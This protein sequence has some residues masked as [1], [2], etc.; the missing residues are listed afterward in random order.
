[1]QDAAW[2]GLRGFRILK[3]G[4]ETDADPVSHLAALGG[5][6]AGTSGSAL[7]AGAG[8]G[9]DAA[10]VAVNGAQEAMQPS[11]PSRGLQARHT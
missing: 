4:Y 1:M 6:S 7:G 11:S 10:V 8:G 2:W 3:E 9:A 5:P